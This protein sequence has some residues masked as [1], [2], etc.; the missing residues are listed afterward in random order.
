MMEEHP[1][2]K[3][4]KRRDAVYDI[5]KAACADILSINRDPW[6]DHPKRYLIGSL[7]KDGAIEEYLPAFYE[8]D[9]L[10]K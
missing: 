2:V 8:I 4:P 3:L 1:S 5:V 7:K 6:P 10:Q 9:A